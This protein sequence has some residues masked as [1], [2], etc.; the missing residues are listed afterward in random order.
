MRRHF[1]F[2]WLPIATLPVAVVLFARDDWPRWVFM[3][4]FAFAIYVSCKWLTWWTTP[5]HGVSVSRQIAYLSLW[6][7]LDAETFFRTP[8]ARSPTAFA[9]CFAL[10]KFSG[11]IALIGIAAS[12]VPEGYAFARGWIGMVGIAFVLH[13]GLFDLLSLTWQSLGVTA[14]PLMNWPMLAT[15]VSDFWGVRW[16]A[17]FRDLTHRFL[18]RPL[19]ARL[20]PHVA[21]LFGFLFSGIVHDLVISVPAEG[22]YGRPTLYFLLQGGAIFLER[23][24][25]GKRLAL[26][27][28]IRGWTFA[29]ITL[30]VP[31]FLLFHPPFVQNVMTPFLDAIAATLLAIFATEIS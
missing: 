30:L 3:W 24:K 18:F 21:L 1:L 13:F 28:G 6:P 26:G 27:H 20:G 4:L 14:K 17:A 22:G 9:W 16:N 31:V 5:T 10:A 25:I 11:G 19:T 15:S 7:G 23:S 8:N 12:R 2:A 29:M